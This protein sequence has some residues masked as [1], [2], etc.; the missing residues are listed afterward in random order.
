MTLKFKKGELSPIQ[1]KNINDFS[2]L[3]GEVH[4][5]RV[6]S[7]YQGE[8]QY[9]GYLEEE[10]F[11]NEVGSLVE[12]LI[13]THHEE[14]EY[15]GHSWFNTYYDCFFISKVELVQIQPEK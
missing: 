3:S 9:L 13:E 7:Q 1:I 14:G 8:L 12:V 11:D 10:D 4:E 15:S 5:N 6:S 2:A